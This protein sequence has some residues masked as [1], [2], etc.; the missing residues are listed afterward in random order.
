VALLGTLGSARRDVQW[1]PV[2]TDVSGRAAA[3]Q[4]NRARCHAA[5]RAELLPPRGS[6]LQ[7]PREP[8]PTRGLR[9]DDLS[10]RRKSATANPKLPEQIIKAHAE[11]I[12]RFYDD[13]PFAVKAYIAF[14]KQPEADVVA[15]LRSVQEGQHL[16]S[17]AVRAGAGGEGD[18]AQQV[19]PR[20]AADLK[21]FDF[22][23]I[24]D[25]SVV[26]AP[27]EGRLLP[28]GVRPER[29]GR[30]A[31]SKASLASSKP[32]TLSMHK[33]E[34]R[35]LTKHYDFERERRQV[36]AL[37]D[38]SLLG[39]RRRVHGHRRPQRLRQDARSSTSSP[40]CFATTRQV[41]IDGKTVDGPAS[42][43]R[44]CFQHRVCCRGEP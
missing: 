25:N 15:H 18:L 4:T 11:A 12:K 36:L 29:E 8:R 7:E 40:A 33:L 26:D 20:I 2:G 34:I 38:V 5:D 16:R 17:R 28:A 14:D 3:L 13:K 43:A 42:I 41:I 35:R 19:D 22:K 1:I 10:V 37:S 32:A 30:G 31:E 9:G 6:R 21:A 44:S 27:G 24:V 23:K 39:R